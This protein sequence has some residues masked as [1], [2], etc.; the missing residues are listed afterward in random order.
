MARSWISRL[1]ATLAASHV[2]SFVSAQIT[3]TPNVLPA[4]TFVESSSRVTALISLASSLKT[5]P[6]PSSTASKGPKVHLIQAGQGGFKFTPQSVSNVAVGDT[7][8]FEFYPPDHSVA[9]AEFESAC[10]PYEYTG[11]GKTGFWSTTQW[12]DTV[13]KITHWNLTINSTEPI[14]FYCAAPGSCKDKWMVGAINP[15]GTQTLDA[16]IRAARRADYQVAPGETIPNEATSTLVNAPTSAPSSP[17]SGG[18]HK[19]SGG[20]IAGIVVGAVA[21]LVICAALFF[22]VGRSKSLK[23]VLKRQ[24]ATMRTSTTPG[25][26][27]EMGQQFGH[28]AEYPAQPSPYL[29]GMAPGQAEY[30]MNSPPMYG[31]HNATEQYPSGWASPGQQSGHLSMMSTMSQQQMDEI[32]AAH[33]Q[34][35]RVAEMHTPEPGQ[36]RFTAELEAPGQRK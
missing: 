36:Q 22:Y 18:S 9:R 35:H 24:D 11:K 5:A 26:G 7:V 10:V 23:E 25:G 30:G 3:S 12:V 6:S 2:I 15:N 33:A 28:Q 21:F 20:V 32:K 8:T 17:S 14:F 34:Q 16:Q 31:Q 29:S 4:P 1:A 19:L 13:D 27:P